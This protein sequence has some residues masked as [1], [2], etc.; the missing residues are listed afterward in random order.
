MSTH[1]SNVQKI[2]LE[3]VE[4]VMDQ[5]TSVDLVSFLKDNWFMITVVIS[6]CGF[7]IRMTKEI[8]TFKKDNETRDANLNT[9]I[10]NGFTEINKSVDAKIEAINE[11]METEFKKVNQQLEEHEQRRVDGSER[12]RIIM[13][14]VEATLITLHNQGYNGPV[15]E[16]LGEITKYKAKKSAE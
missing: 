3:G 7:M 2:C 10:D 15:T 1:Y 5:N 4:L 13:S 6:L 11:K 9:K 14:G 8:V 16:S 12:T